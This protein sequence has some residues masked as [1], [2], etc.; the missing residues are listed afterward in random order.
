MKVRSEKGPVE[1]IPFF[2]QAIERDPNFA[3][4]YASLGSCYGNSGENDLSHENIGKAYELRDRAS[5]RE[6]LRISNI[7]FFDRGELEK[8]L[9]ATKL[10]AEEYP[11]DKLAHDDLALTYIQLGQYEMAVQEQEEAVRLDPDDLMQ[12]FQLI[13][14]YEFINNFDEAKATWQKTVARYPMNPDLHVEG[15][16]LAFLEGDPAEMAR[17]VA[18]ASDKPGA[19]EQFLETTA[20]IEEFYGHLNKAQELRRRLIALAVQ[21]NRKETA[22]R[23]QLALSWKEADYGYSERARQGAL[24]ALAETSALSVQI[25]AAVVLARAGDPIRAEAIAQDLEKRFPLDT[26][27][28]IHTYWL[29]TIRAAIALN[30]NNPAEA[31]QFLQAASQYDL[32]LGGGL[33]AVYL[34]GAA[35][36][37]QHQGGAAALEFQKILDHRGIV[38]PSLQ[39][40]LAY[41]GLARAY[42][43]AGDTLR[44]KAAYQDFLSLWKDAD[45]DIPILKQAKA[46]YGKLQ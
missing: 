3:S 30:R 11:K 7:Y 41:L 12:C 34:R 44:A 22:A 24:A 29:P 19:D 10:W 26:G 40:A 35:Y 16:Y 9:E 14:G 8:A 1:A 15:Y 43:I 42:L 31:I 4:A 13:N 21:S 23:E 6:R 45:P 32:F 27:L 18:W 5:E 36:L 28:R 17:Q 39:G 33:Y 25:D 20:T 38:G 37:L 2:K 46:E